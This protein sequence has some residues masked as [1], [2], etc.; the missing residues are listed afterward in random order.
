MPA[1][2]ALRDR[3]ERLESL[4]EISAL[5]G[6]YCRS[7]D[8]RDLE[9][10]ASLWVPTAW[11]ILGGVRYNGLPDICAMIKR[12]A[13]DRFAE[14]MHHS[15]NLVIDCDPPFRRATA[16]WDVNAVTRRPDGRWGQTAA[17]YADTMISDRG[18]WKLSGRV[19]TTKFSRPL[20]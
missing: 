14:T 9:G 19:T 6:R 5:V 11:W 17:S 13:W 1:D 12:D 2:G 7:V 10:F 16:V 4:A 3:V 20:T 18:R 15:G 8:T